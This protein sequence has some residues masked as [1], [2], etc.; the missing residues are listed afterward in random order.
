M[1]K[2]LIE[3]DEDLFVIDGKTFLVTFE[4]SQEWTILQLFANIAM[5]TEYFLKH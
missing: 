4:I 1:D 3:T 2:K 5:L